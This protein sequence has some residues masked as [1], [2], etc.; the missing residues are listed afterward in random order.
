MITDLCPNQYAAA[1]A[2]LRAGFATV[3]AEFGLTEENTPSNPAF[4]TDADLQRVVARGFQLIGAE[5]GE[6]VLGCA[7]VG[8]SQSREHTWELRHLAVHPDARHHGYGEALVAEAGRRA[9]AA[10]AT[11]LRIG[12]VAD[13]QRLSDW[14]RRLG[15]VTVSAGE[16]YPGLVFA[17]DHLELMVDSDVLST[18]R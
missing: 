15:F 7:F 13:N 16:R 14:Y 10:G 5:V 6:R 3:A 11:V 2:V 1:L 8:P 9:Q 4:W 18:K 12:I 17:V